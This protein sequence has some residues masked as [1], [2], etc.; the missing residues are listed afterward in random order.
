MV[1]PS[2]PG[3]PAIEK[4]PDPDAINARFCASASLA[5]SD[6]TTRVPTATAGI[7]EPIRRLSQRVDGGMPKLS[8]VDLGD[9]VLDAEDLDQHGGAHPHAVALL[10]PVHR[11]R[12]LIDGGI[13]LGA[14][15]Q[16]MHDDRIA[17]QAR[18]LRRVDA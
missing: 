9:P 14:A 6:A 7:P 10:P 3:P 16:R 2:W 11:A 13:D 1:A 18:E 4:F 15:R 5:S 8:S 12:V 17:F